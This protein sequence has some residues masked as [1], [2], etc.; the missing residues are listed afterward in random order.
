MPTVAEKR[1]RLR[2]LHESGCF[3]IPNPF[4]V[5]SARYL[6][7]LGFKALATAGSGPAYAMGLP[8]GA[9]SL[10]V[11]M[12]HI[13]S[14]AQAT[15]VPLSADF[16]NGFTDTPPD[17][18]ANVARCLATGAAGV[19]IEDKS[20]S[21]ALYD[22]ELAVA[23]VRAAR[24]AIDAEGGKAVFV[25]RTEC[26]LTAHP[27]PREEA[28][29]RLRAYAAAGADCLFAPGARSAEDIAAIV[30]A[31]APKPVNVLIGSASELTVAGLAALGVRRI[32]V[33][34]ALARIAF[35]AFMTA[36]CDIAR[37]G[38]FDSLAAVEEAGNLDAFFRADAAARE[39]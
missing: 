12:A 32:S 20:G 34:G 29:R 37:T 28:I 4:D 11:M 33:G 39:K 10:E 5:G 15:D 35:G 25:A 9:V 14:L 17:V 22:E 6:Q 31:V 27:R 30:T 3:V 16:G 21:G 26:F 24:D 2:A 8:N 13:A 38:R 36:A 19:S 7:S 1:Q 18:A 23:R